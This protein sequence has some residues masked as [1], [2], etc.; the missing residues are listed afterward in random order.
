MAPPKAPAV[1]ATVAQ[2]HARD[3]RRL[4]TGASTSTAAARRTSRGNHDERE[5]HDYGNGGRQQ[6]HECGQLNPPVPGGAPRGAAASRSGG[7]GAWIMAARYSA[8]RYTVNLYNGRR[9]NGPPGA[10]LGAE[11]MQAA[12]RQLGCQWSQRNPGSS[13]DPVPPYRGRVPGDLGHRRELPAVG[14]RRPEAKLRI[15]PG[16]VCPVGDHRVTLAMLV[17]PGPVIY[18][19]PLR[20]PAFPGGVIVVSD[21]RR[22]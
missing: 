12:A 18:G 9:S 21:G 2:S 1:R 16:P 17:R 14:P 11:R 6:G 8:S 22:P 19:R 7:P 10:P 5:E 15:R 3:P 4:L 20:C 13:A